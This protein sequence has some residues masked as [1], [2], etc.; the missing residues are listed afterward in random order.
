MKEKLVYNV[1]TGATEIL[2]FLRMN[3][4][5]HYNS[6]IGNFDHVDQLRRRDRVD[7]WLRNSNLCWLVVFWIFWIVS[8]KC[9]CAVL[10]DL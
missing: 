2:K 9:A 6:T 5:H 1:D 8:K 7:H 4:I 10:E 3:N